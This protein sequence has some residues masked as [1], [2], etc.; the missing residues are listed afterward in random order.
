[1]S[2]LYCPCQR[3]HCRTQLHPRC[4][5]SYNK[6]SIARIN[7]WNLVCKSSSFSENKTGTVVPKPCTVGPKLLYLYTPLQRTTKAN[8]WFAILITY[9]LIFCFLHNTKI[10]IID[11]RLIQLLVPQVLADLLSI[12][13]ILCLDFQHLQVFSFFSLTFQLSS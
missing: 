6:L 1:M 8:I 2:S 12:C 4:H 11:L 5:T 3:S 10:F 9:K 13:S 7:V